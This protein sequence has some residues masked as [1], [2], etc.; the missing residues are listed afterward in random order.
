MPTK[1]EQSDVGMLV[2]GANGDIPRIVLAP[3]DPPMRS[4]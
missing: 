3:G 2:H 4:S 1:P